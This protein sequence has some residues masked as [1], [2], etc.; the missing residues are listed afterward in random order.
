MG[1]ITMRRDKNA[2]MF[3]SRK[4]GT[5][6]RFA[7]GPYAKARVPEL[8][9]IKITDWCDMGCSFCYQ[10]SW[11][12]GKHASM[13]NMNYII[14]QLSSA[15]VPEIAAGGGETLDHPH[16]VEIFKKFYE[17]G[18]IPNFTTKKPARVRQLWSEIS[19][20]IGGFAYSAETPGQIYSASKVMREIPQ[21]KIALHY[22]MGLGDKNHFKDYMKAASDVGYRVT[23]LGYKT[24][25]RGK[26]VIP[27][28]YEWWIEAVNELIQEG[29]CPSLS[30]DTPLAAEYDGRMPVDKYNYH[31]Q[32]GKFSMYIDAVSM[33][34]GASSFESLENLVDFNDNW[35]KSYKTI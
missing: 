11:L 28:P 27:F 20:Y 3:F 35:I 17:A 8:V 33:K 12:G 15:K 9:D 5:K 6:L 23:L 4:D 25:G 24:S 18:I 31:T 2:I 14:E 29:N 7:I 21:S 32:E 22:V 16:V 1:N 19:P 34:M 10:G 30:I 26:D 13:D